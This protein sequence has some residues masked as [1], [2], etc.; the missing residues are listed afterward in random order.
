MA[1]VMMVVVLVMVRS[2]SW[3]WFESDVLLFLTVFRRSYNALVYVLGGLVAQEKKQPHKVK[4]IVSDYIQHHFTAEKAHGP[5]MS[6]L[7]ANFQTLQ[8]APL[9]KSLKV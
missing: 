8:P 2:W 9:L 6:Q 4:A 7:L 3:S 5:L 1:F